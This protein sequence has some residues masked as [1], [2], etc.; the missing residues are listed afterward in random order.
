LTRT[1]NSKKSEFHESRIG[2]PIWN[3]KFMERKNNLN[4]EFPNLELE[5]GIPS[6]SHVNYNSKFEIPN[7]S[8][9]S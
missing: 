6:D 2:I 8:K 9:K 3:S 4:L 7:R 5:L 1:E